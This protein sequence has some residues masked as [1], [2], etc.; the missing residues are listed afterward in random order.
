MKK[1]LAVVFIC[2]ALAMIPEAGQAQDS[3]F[4][5]GAMINGPTGIS[6]KGWLDDRVAVG[7]AVTFNVGDGRDL[8]YTHADILVHSDNFINNENGLTGSLNIY[9]GGG[10][11]LTFLNNPDDTEVD[12]RVPFGTVYG[13]ENNPVDIFFEIVP[14]L[15]IEEPTR[16][17]LNG[18]M[19][20]R[21]YLN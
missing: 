7:G 4:G 18:A 9:Y 16:F 15:T 1:L 21:Y 10:V 2:S 3:G 5:I 8:F 20:I 19:G 12:L 6:Y 17:F 13:M 14:T 11:A